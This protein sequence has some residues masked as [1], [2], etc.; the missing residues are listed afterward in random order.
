MAGAFDRDSI[1]RAYGRWAPVY[2]LVFG[3]VFAPGRSAAVAAAERIGGRVLDVGVGTGI[4]LAQYSSTNRVIGLDISDHSIEA[5]FIVRRGSRLAVASYGRTT[6]PPGII[7]GAMK[8]LGH[9]LGRNTVK[10][11]LAEAGVAPAP[12]R[13][14]I[15]ATNCAQL[16][17]FPHEAA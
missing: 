17:G 4:A 2:D 7:V 3:K 9:E 5:V 14:K 11:M 16:Y 6:L 1:T 15:T 12:D 8:N 13:R 10:R